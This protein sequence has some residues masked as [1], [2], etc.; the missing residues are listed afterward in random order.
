[1]A[2]VDESNRDPLTRAAVKHLLGL[3]ALSIA[4]FAVLLTVLGWAAS[5]TGGGAAASRAVDLAK[6]TI[7]TS[8]RAEPPNL[9]STRL[10]DTYSVMILNHVVEGLFRPGEHGDLLPGVAE[11]WDIRTTGATFWLRDDALWSDGK[12]VTAH[13]FVFAWQTVVDPKTASQ[14]AFILYPV[15]NAEKINRGELPREA[16]GV[17]ATN[18][19]ELEVEFENPIAYF[20]KLVASTTYMPIREDFYKSRNGRYAADAE[21]LLYNGP[22]RI[23][24]WV[25]SAS[26]RMEKNATYWDRDRIK[27]DAVDVAYM[28]RD[29]VA[30]LNLFQDGRIADA[31]QLP[32]EALAQVL[33]QRWPLHRYSDGSVWFL[34]VNHRPGRITANYHFRRA[35]QLANDPTELV[36]K[37]LKTPSFTVAQSLFPSF[38]RGEHGLFRQEHPPPQVKTDVAA[39]RAELELAEKELGIDRFPPL[40]FLSD[41]T[42]AAVSQSEYVQEYYRR[43]LGLEIRIDRQNFRQRLAKQE[44]GDFDITLY[45]WSAD[46]DDLLSFADLFAS[47]N[48]NNHGR[49]KNPELDAQVR[50]AQQSLDP[51]VRF[52]AFAEV[53]RIL[54]DDAVIV[55]GYER[56]VLYVQDRRLKNVVTRGIGPTP[57]YTFAY[58]DA[59][60]P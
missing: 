60:D 59:E 38:L 24:R 19:R 54:I 4:G 6:R 33:Q 40:V 12:P 36:Y 27:L 32:G 47:W 41:D 45:G 30:R 26:L 21:D 1:V 39:A 42:P 49:Y 9:D 29:A 57:D 46:Y 55:L 15:K 5:V 52:A 2:E 11:R 25:H 18:D 37:V 13:D 14:Y 51:E 44:A 23:T 10:T 7:T 43:T 28:T 16:L 20:D 22:F 8:I 17:H 58:I 31:D 34:Q 48:L 56:G 53:Q 3:A 50:T 35:L